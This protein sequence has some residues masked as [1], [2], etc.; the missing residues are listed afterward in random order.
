[1]RKLV[2]LFALMSMSAAALGQV[3][4][5]FPAQTVA[6]QNSERDVR[7]PL[8]QAGQG[9]ALRSRGKAAGK[10]D[11]RVG[12][13]VGDINNVRIGRIDAVDSEGA[14]VDYGK[15]STKVPLRAFGRAGTGL[16]MAMTRAE[17]LQKAANPR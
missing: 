7:N 16:V 6:Q 9:V 4:A 10:A 17:F 2:S 8:N 5:R 15:G 11:I 14:V 1:M 12:L 3:G 13:R